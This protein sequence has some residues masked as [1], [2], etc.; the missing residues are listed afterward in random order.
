[1]RLVGREEELER[2][3]RFVG[4]AATSPG[5]LVLEGEAG[6]GKTTLWQAGIA[7]AESAGSLVLRATPSGAEAALAYVAAADL[8]APV[9]EEALGRLPDV[10]RQALA[11]GDPVRADRP[12]SERRAQRRERRR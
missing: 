3:T 8:L 7:H 11:G 10:Q 9:A 5:V 1:V 4:R 12:R 6:S 2:I